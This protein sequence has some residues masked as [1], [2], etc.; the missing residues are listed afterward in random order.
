MMITDAMTSNAQAFLR[1]DV[2]VDSP[3]FGAGAISVFG[4]RAAEYPFTAA[5]QAR[6]DELSSELDY[7]ITY[8]L[9]SELMQSA[10]VTGERAGRPA[11]GIGVFI[12]PE[13]YPFYDTIRAEEPRGALLRD[14]FTGPNQTV[15]GRRLA[16]QMDARVGDQV[17]I[18]TAE[19]LYTVTGIVADAAESAFD[20]ANSILFSFAYLNRNEM[21]AFGLE[22]LA[23]TRAYLRLPEDVSQERAL[24]HIRMRWPQRPDGRLWRVQTADDVLRQNAFI[25]DAISRFVL[26]LSLVGLVIGGVGIINTMLVAVNRRSIEIAVLK[27][28]GLQGQSI[29]QVFMAEALLMSILGSLIGI[30]VGYLLSLIARDFGQQAFAV[31]LP[32]RL[33][34]DP[35]LVG[36]ALGIAITVFFSFLPTLMATR[37]RPNLVLRQGNIPMARAGCLPTILSLLVLIVGIGL[38]VDLIIGSYRFNVNLPPPLTL[39]ILGTLI[40]FILL[41]VISALMWALVWLLGKLPS[42]RIPSLRIALRGLTTHRARTALSLLALIIGMTALSGTLIMARSINILLY[43]SISEPMGGNVIMVPL[44]LTRGLVHAQL[45]NAQGVN[46]Y[47]DVRFPSGVSV[48]SING[49]RDYRAQFD[50]EDPQAALRLAQLGLVLG[51]N[52]YGSPPRGQLRDG[53][54]LGPEDAGQANIVLPYMP[55]FEVLGV[56]VGSTLTLRQSRQGFSEFKEYTVVGIVTPDAR[57]GL[58]PF[59]LSDSAVQ[60]PLDMLPT[61]IPFDFIIADVERELVDEVMAAVATVPGVFVFDVAI[62]DSII[63]RL[64]NQLAALP[65]LVAGLSLFAATA[66]IATTVS[67]ATMERRR[68][69]AILKAVGVSRW[70]ALR[71]LLIENGIVGFAGGIISLLPT[72]LILVAVPLLTE[73]LVTL[74]T[75]VDL[76]ILMLLLSIGITLLATM[77]T[78]WSA[79]GEK[80]L[81]VLRVE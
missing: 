7:E 79:A 2:R 5:I 40:V 49:R 41:G 28:L 59:S 66:L 8:V 26:L 61:A 16:D 38:L 62:F 22:P 31:P 63:S 20:N 15:I 65:L 11:L 73:G 19:S 4:N 54:F 77:M 10:V 81:N 68:Q 50:R 21:E 23:A 17:R 6:I 42:F 24:T 14:L 29:S 35:A 56:Q 1:G 60:V 55:E 72:A 76:V 67:L 18:G 33:Y 9:A 30:V 52:V 75:P 69:I 74:P 57:T 46:G 27:T 44:P 36:M 48:D 70:Q 12:D 64:L 45:D 39:G 43:T 32:W 71:Q 34:A 58:I 47:R 53:R 78:A 80:P 3:A 37:V 51:I 13:V 25:A